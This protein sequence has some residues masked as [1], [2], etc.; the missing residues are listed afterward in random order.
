MK[1]IMIFTAVVLLV[2]SCGGNEESIEPSPK[3]LVTFSEEP[4][5][6]NG[7]I[8]FVAGIQFGFA[9]SP[10]IIEYQVLDGTQVVANGSAN[11]NINTDGGLNAFFETAI[12]EEAINANTY[13][14][15]TLTVWLDPENKVTADTYTDQQN[16]NLWKKEDVD[17]P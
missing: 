5:Y 8:K 9:G 1:K 17:I 3:G 7:N 16:V 13:S 14:G 15:K 11:A 12:V 10:V 6:S 4:V 2:F